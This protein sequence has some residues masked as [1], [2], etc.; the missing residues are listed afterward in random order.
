MGGGGA[1]GAGEG[2]EGRRMGRCRRP[3]SSA[4]HLI[5]MS[6]SDAP[7]QAGAASRPRGKPQS[8][9][10]NWATLTMPRVVENIKNAKKDQKAKKRT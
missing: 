5:T 3:E 2:S 9:R 7:G 6:L 1:S 8:K 4:L 10:G